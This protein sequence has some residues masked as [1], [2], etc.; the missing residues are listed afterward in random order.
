MFAKKLNVVGALVSTKVAQDSGIPLVGND[1]DSAK[2]GAVVALGLDYVDTGYQAGLQVVKILKGTAVKD[3]PIE[4]QKKG[5]LAV[6]T[7]AAAAQK[8]KLPEALL[9]RAQEKYD[10]ISAKQ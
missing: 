5:L 9:S 10:K 3:I 2:R 8:V 7:A 1:P 4:R 6:N